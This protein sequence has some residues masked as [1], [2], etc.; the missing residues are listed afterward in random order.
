MFIWLIKPTTTTDPTL[1]ADGNVARDINGNTFSANNVA[2]NF[3]TQCSN[4]VSPPSQCYDTDIHL[5]NTGYSI[6]TNWIP[7]GGNMIPGYTYEMDLVI[8][9]AF[10]NFNAPTI[11]LDNYQPILEARANNTA[12]STLYGYVT[13]SDLSLKELSSNVRT[14][15]TNVINPVVVTYSYRVRNLGPESTLDVHLQ[16]T[17]PNGCTVATGG[18]APTGFFNSCSANPGVQFSTY[19]CAASTNPPIAVTH[20]VTGTISIQ[21]PAGF[22]GLQAIRFTVSS[23]SIDQDYGN[24]YRTFPVF[25][26]PVMS[27]QNN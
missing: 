27:T 5:R 8:W 18:A 6:A 21:C 9:N 26:T 25:V 22:T 17:P 24:N 20:D 4:Y 16:F 11:L 19:R 12:N 1:P 15:S 14:I 2:A 23:S 3:F 7:F 13:T 10:N